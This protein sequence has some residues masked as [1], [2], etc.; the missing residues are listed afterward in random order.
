M[1]TLVLAAAPLVMWGQR[2]ALEDYFK[3]YVAAMNNLG[4]A[5]QPMDDRSLFRADI[6]QTYF[7]PDRNS[8]VYNHLRSDGTR[9]LPAPEY[10]DRIVTEFPAGVAFDFQD[11][12]VVGTHIGDAGSEWLVRLVW[13][14]RPTGRPVGRFPLVFALQVSGTTASRISARILSIDAAE[15]PATEPPATT[16]PP[17]PVSETTPPPTPPAD[18]PPPLQALV[19]D[20]VPVEGGTFTMG[21]TREQGGECYS[22]EKP[23]HPVTLSSFRMGKYEVTQAQWEAVMGTTVRMQRDRFGRQLPLAGEGPDYPMYFVSWQEAQEFIRRLNA[24]TG[25]SYGLPTEAEWEYAARGGNKSRDDKFAGGNELGSRVWYVGN[26]AGTSHPV[27][28][29][30]PNELG[31]HD[32]SGNV[33]EWCTDWSGS[34]RVGSQRNPEGPGR[35]QSRRNRGGSWRN[36]GRLCRVAARQHNLPD[37]RSNDL[38]F[39]LV[40]R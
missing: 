40:T 3:G 21:C 23:A 24:R 18:L 13:L 29:K 32:M 35:G 9:F 8:L 14:T 20:M 31:L 22:D 19:R 36:E 34:Y 10:L 1:L 5:R 39:R 27:G 12:E 26:S 38:G 2:Q 6:L 28:K 7:L 17:A 25:G 37:T 33:R 30:I 15:P 4:D 11:L 16:A